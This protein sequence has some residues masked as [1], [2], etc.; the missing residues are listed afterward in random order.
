MQFLEGQVFQ[1]FKHCLLLVNDLFVERDL[2]ADLKYK[3][4][5]VA[6]RCEFSECIMSSCAI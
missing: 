5:R 2:N 6:N 3:K 4:F 1:N